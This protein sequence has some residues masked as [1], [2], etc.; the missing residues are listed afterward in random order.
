MG[1]AAAARNSTAARQ[2]PHG[3]ASG[4]S[5]GRRAAQRRPSSAVLPSVGKRKGSSRAAP[6][7]AGR[8]AGDADAELRRSPGDGIAGTLHSDRVVALALSE[9]MDREAEAVRSMMRRWRKPI[10][11]VPIPGVAG[12]AVPSRA[13]LDAAKAAVIRFYER[14]EALGERSDVSKAFHL[15]TGE[16]RLRLDWNHAKHR[17]LRARLDCRQK[18]DRWENTFAMTSGETNALSDIYVCGTRPISPAA[19]SS[20]LCHE[21]LHNLARRTRRGNSFLGEEIEHMAMALIGDPQ[22][23]A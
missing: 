22:I 11:K 10:L 23:S 18:I 21:G 4:P 1:R 14:E 15:I 2:R 20:L 16:R 3:R 12:R 5:P 17:V 6:A 13:M 7:G 19:L 8:R 9:M